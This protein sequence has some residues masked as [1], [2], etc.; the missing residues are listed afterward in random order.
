MHSN[1]IEN[2]VGYKITIANSNSFYTAFCLRSAPIPNSIKI[3]LENIEVNKIYYY[4]ALVGRLGWFIQFY[5]LPNINLKSQFLPK[6]DTE[7]RCFEILETK[8]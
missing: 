7:H 2:T 6:L 1:Q 8:I 5:S 3:G 4:S